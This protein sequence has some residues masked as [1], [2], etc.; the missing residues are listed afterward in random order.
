MYGKKKRVTHERKS[1]RWW[2]RTAGW[3]T[4]QIT[5]CQGV[6]TKWTVTGHGGWEGATIMW[7]GEGSTPSA[8]SGTKFSVW[9]L[10]RNGCTLTTIWSWLCS[11]GK[12]HSVVSN[13]RAN[14]GQLKLRQFNHNQRG[15]G[16]CYTQSRGRQDAASNNGAS[17]LNLPGD[18][19]VD[20]QMDGASEG[21]EG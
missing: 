18:L 8:Q 16:V 6:S 11:E 21:Y 5:S 17:T 12:E 10:G 1:L 15:G 7:R 4:W 20:R 19:T 13:G 9:G 3:S 2:W 14:Y